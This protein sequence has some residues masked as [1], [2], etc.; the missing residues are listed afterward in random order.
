MDSLPVRLATCM[1]PVSLILPHGKG[2]CVFV[3]V[4][5]TQSILLLKPILGRSL[6]KCHSECRR[7][8]PGASIP[9]KEKHIEKWADLEHVLCQR[10]HGI[11]RAMFLWKK[12]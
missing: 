11:I 9:S 12:D 6:K 8:F 3:T 7:Y 5:S 1:H 10:K 2:V 4:G